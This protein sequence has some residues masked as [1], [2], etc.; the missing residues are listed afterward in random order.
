MD[1]TVNQDPIQTA[2][3]VEPGAAGAQAS[4][5]GAA[6]ASAAERTFTQAEL[7]RQIDARLQRERAKFADYDA[8]KQELSDLKAAN[9][10]RDIRDQVALD[11]KIP[12][13][14]LTGDT[15]EACEQQADAILA[16]A[17]GSSFPSVPDG[18]E[19]SPK[20]GSSTRDQ[21]AEWGAKAFGL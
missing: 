17:R 14:L 20:A 4:N 8:V 6:P 21:F 3:A 12:V 9:A 7:N 5:T 16:F 15:K 19:V 2:Q 11:K 18:G 1:E 13:S 10:I